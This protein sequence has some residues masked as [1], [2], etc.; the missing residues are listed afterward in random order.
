VGAAQNRCVIDGN[1]RDAAGGGRARGCAIV[2]GE[3]DGAATG[4]GAL[5]AV[6]VGDAAQRGLVL[7]DG[8]CA[9]QGQRAG[10]VIPAAGDAILVGKAQRVLAIGIVAG[11]LNG[12]ASD[13]GVVHIAER[14]AAID[15]H[16]SAVLG[17]AGV[18][19]GRGHDRCIVDSGD[20]DAPGSSRAG[21]RA[22][23]DREADGA[24]TGA[25]VVAAVAV[26]DAAQRG[27]VLGDGGCA[28]QGQRAGGGIPAAGDAILVGEAQRVLAIGV[29]A[30]DLN[31]GASDGGVVDITAR[32]AAINGHCSAVLGEAGVA[33]G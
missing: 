2:D 32:E 13:R 6:A 3:A 22:I 27:L 17:E 26:G 19:G 5:A 31:G 21:S 29:V 28:G 14:E 7:G 18:A 20:G 1:D 15:G 16:C 23:A 10:G 24:R 25:G 30:G 9:G 12:G 4:A 8:G 11:D 33:G